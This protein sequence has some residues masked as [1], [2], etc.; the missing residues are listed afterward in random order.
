MSQQQQLTQTR[1]TRSTVRGAGDAQSVGEQTS[2]GPRSTPSPAPILPPIGSTGTAPAAG[3]GTSAPVDSSIAVSGQSATQPAQA[4]ATGSAQM[5]VTAGNDVIQLPPSEAEQRRRAAQADE[6]LVQ[7]QQAV[8]DD[9]RARRER[10]LASLAV[11]ARTN[12]ASTTSP[13][14]LFATLGQQQP[15]SSPAVYG[16]VPQSSYQ[17]YSMPSYSHDVSLGVP[18]MTSQLYN[19]SPS[20]AAAAVR[21]SRVEAKSPEHKSPEPQAPPY[22]ESEAAPITEVSELQRMINLTTLP[23]LKAY[24]MSQLNELIRLQTDGRRPIES[25][26]R[27]SPLQQLQPSGQPT[28]TPL[29]QRFAPMFGLQQS[30]L[31]IP[32]T[33]PRPLRS[34]PYGAPNFGFPSL[35]RPDFVAPAAAVDGRQQAIDDQVSQASARGVPL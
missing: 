13:F 25:Q 22:S 23:T 26:A 29:T 4:S 9:I 28:A 20:S 18:S 3:S 24:L 21:P 12:A 1:L 31:S 10:K 30:P 2:T 33:V 34:T 8:I 16:A 35:V 14:G 17:S 27:M 11:A 32:P 15:Y 5:L 7:R 19:P 6:D